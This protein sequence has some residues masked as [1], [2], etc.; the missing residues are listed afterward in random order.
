MIVH[1]ARIGCR[2]PDRLDVTRKGG[3]VF[4][5]SWPLLMAAK[6]GQVSSSEYTERYT[7]EMRESYRL[8]RGAWDELLGRPRVVLCC[9]CTDPLRCHRTLLAKLLAK[10]G[11]RRGI[12]VELAGELAS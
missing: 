9:Y 3:S 10:V 6:R 1:T 2:D 4:A 7:A 11:A 12:E 5:P 8:H